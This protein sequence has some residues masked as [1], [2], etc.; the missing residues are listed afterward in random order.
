MRALKKEIDELKVA[1]CVACGHVACAG[2]P[3]GEVK[4]SMLN[5]PRAKI[6]TGGRTL[7]G[8]DD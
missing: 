7:F 1:P 2:V 5:R 3:N 6:A 4:T 8:G